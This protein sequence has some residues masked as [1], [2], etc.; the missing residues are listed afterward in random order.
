MAITISESFAAGL[1]VPFR[2]IDREVSPVGTLSQTIVDTGDATGGSASML[3]TATYEM[4]GFHPII[5][6]TKVLTIDNLAAAQTVRAGMSNVGNE[7]LETDMYEIVLA[8]EEGGSNYAVFDNLTVPIEPSSREAEA[9]VFAIVWDTN[10]DTKSYDARL[11]A[12]FYDA[13]A[14]ARGKEKGRSVPAL[15]GGIR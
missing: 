2:G 1:Y 4:F 3:V 13:E 14:M 11:F 7:R 9:N 6:V 15:L 10:T 5:I 8:I 12:V